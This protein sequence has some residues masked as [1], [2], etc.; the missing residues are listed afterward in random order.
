MGSYDVEQLRH[1]WWWHYKLERV[2]TRLS[3]AGIGAAPHVLYI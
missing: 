2:D 3:R 1:L